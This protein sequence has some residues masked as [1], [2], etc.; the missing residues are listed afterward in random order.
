MKK[1]ASLL[2]FLFS[3]FGFAS[4][5]D[6]SEMCP[7][8]QGDRI[9]IVAPHPDDEALGCSGIIQRAAKAGAKLRV[10]YLTNGDHNEFAFIAYKKRIPIFKSE[11][12]GMG[13]MRRREAISAMAVLGLKEENLY[14]LG[15]PDFGLF[16]IFGQYW[17]TDKPFRSI[18]TRIS[19]V[20]Y[21]DNFS[22]GSSYVGENILKD[23]K[24]IISDFKPNRIFVS[25]PAD[26][27]G[28]H[29]AAYLFLEIALASLRDSIE[30]PQINLYLIHKVGWP[31]PRHYHPYLSIYPPQDLSDSDLEWSQIH[32]NNEEVNKKHQALLCYK[33]QTRSSAFYLLAF[34]RNNELFSVYPQI[35]IGLSGDDVT[36]TEV[37]GSSFIDGVSEYFK[38]LFSRPVE[39]EKNSFTLRR[40]GN[41]LTYSVNNNY[42]TVSISKPPHIKSRFYSTVY[43]FGYRYGVDFS[44]MPKIRLVMKPDKIAIFD[45]KKELPISDVVFR[46]EKDSLT[47]S[48]PWALLD[49]PDFIL[50][51]MKTSGKDMSDRRAFRKISIDR[52]TVKK[53][54]NVCCN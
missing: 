31:L 35:T 34:A 9:L 36:K 19:S 28:D 30:R 45:K 44:S 26:V 38:S 50:S 11:F 13:E 27:N 23:M 41:Y 15:Y 33:S 12:I 2:I 6:I 46:S 21:K 51:L 43:L 16:S 3:L 14:F 10:V 22:F 7:I 18:L 53:G 1:T 40:A 52:A 37:G 24:K 39:I 42:F 48:L 29:K 47:A 8:K 4:G 17:Q 49:S 32:L 5:A 25:H 20:P 54:R